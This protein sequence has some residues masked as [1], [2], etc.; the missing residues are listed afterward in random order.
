MLNSGMTV[1]IEEEKPITER[2]RFQLLK[3]SIIVYFFLKVMNNTL[4]LEVTHYVLV[5][6]MN[7]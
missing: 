5:K 4:N 7:K 6:M 1:K 3:T 2:S